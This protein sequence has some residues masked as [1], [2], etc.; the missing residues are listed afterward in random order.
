MQYLHWRNNDLRAN[1]NG[2]IYVYVSHNS[3][4]LKQLQASSRLP[5]KEKGRQFT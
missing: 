1:K 2:A 4:D 3:R 5:R